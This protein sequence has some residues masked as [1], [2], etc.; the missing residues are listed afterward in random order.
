[1]HIEHIDPSGGDDS[2]NL[3]LACSSCNLSKSVATTAL[4]FLTGTEVALFNPRIQYWQDHFEWIDNGLRILGK[5][6]IGRATISRLKMNQ[7]RLVRARRNWIVS[8][9]HPPG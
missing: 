9:T 3:C 6:P 4:D 1:M 7:P 5:T 2:D 8:G